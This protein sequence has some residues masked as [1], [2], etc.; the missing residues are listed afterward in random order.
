MELADAMH[1][2]NDDDHQHDPR[3]ADQGIDDWSGVDDGIDFQDRAKNGSNKNDAASS[4]SSAMSTDESGYM[5]KHFSAFDTDQGVCLDGSVPVFWL[6]EAV[7]SSSSDKWLVHLKGGGWCATEKE[8]ANWVKVNYQSGSGPQSGDEGYST[9]GNEADL[10][11]NITGVGIMSVDPSVN[12]EF[13]DWNTVYVWYCDGGSYMGDKDGTTTV[14]KETL[15]FRGKR[16]L[17][18]VMKT[19][20]YDFGM[21]TATEVVLTG[22]SAGG[23]A[24]IQQCDNVGSLVES[25]SSD[26]KF[27]C[28]ADAGFFVN[29]TDFD[30]GV[31]TWTSQWE[32][33]VTTHGAV[34]SMADS[35]KREHSGHEW[36]CW[37][38]DVALPH[39]THDTF[40]VQSVLDLWQL[41]YNFFSS[42]LSDAKAGHDCLNNPLRLCTYATFAGIQNFREQLLIKLKSVASS[43]SKVSYF[44]DACFKHT[45]TDRN[46]IFMIPIVSDSTI[47]MSV[48]RWL[49][50]DAVRNLD[51]DPWPHQNQQCD[52]G[53]EWEQFLDSGSSSKL[54]MSTDDYMDLLDELAEGAVRP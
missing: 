6:R 29:T 35:C 26:V 13:F 34:S 27:K 19:L 47:S 30:G 49:Q 41:P 25:A 18:G 42:E 14:G 24:T 20:L 22:S 21:D 50:G 44:V 36:Q 51:E 46:S 38:A 1:L 28:L 4:D 33:M 48:H 16:V 10:P 17:E 9:D 15:Y 52:W 31:G 32:T 7:S 11:N 43:C 37:F 53:P 54:M 45:Q 5:Y 2:G 3:T 8:C 12:P 23:I 40:L 39:V